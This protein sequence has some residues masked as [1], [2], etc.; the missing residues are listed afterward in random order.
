MF[1]LFRML[2]N[3][4][5]SN[6]LLEFNI[7]CENT[8]RC[9]LLH[10]ASHLFPVFEPTTEPNRKSLQRVIKKA[11]NSATHPI[12]KLKYVMLLHILLMHSNECY[13]FI[14]DNPIRFE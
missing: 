5:A 6:L 14:L 7:S 13:Q 4:E 10:K 11:N 8:K 1:G 2:T 9:D 3:D 12:V